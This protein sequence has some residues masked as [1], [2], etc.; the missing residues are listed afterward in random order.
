[1]C[2]VTSAAFLGA[3]RYHSPLAPADTSASRNS[4][5]FGP[6]AAGGLKIVWEITSSGRI[7][8]LAS[9]SV[10]WSCAGTVSITPSNSNRSYSK[11]GHST[12]HSCA[13]PAFHQAQKSLARPDRGPTE[14]LASGAFADAPRRP[15]PSRTTRESCVRSSHVCTLRATRQDDTRNQPSRCLYDKKAGLGCFASKQARASATLVVDSL[16]SSRS[17]RPRQATT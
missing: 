16:E 4:S 3:L 7:V 13:P 15:P 10:R 9:R 11:G 12:R 2:T 6:G 17:L 8:S 5:S 1:M 14:A